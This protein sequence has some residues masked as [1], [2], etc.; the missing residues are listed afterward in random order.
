MSRL[1]YT[2]RRSRRIRRLM[3]SDPTRGLRLT[4]RLVA[5][6]LAD[7]ARALGVPAPLAPAYTPR[8]IIDAI[9]EAAHG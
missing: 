3:R 8:W 6:L 2:R 1:S 9:L 7:Q 4:D 5:R